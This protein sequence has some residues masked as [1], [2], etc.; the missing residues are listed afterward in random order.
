MTHLSLLLDSNG[1]LKNYLTW[2][3]KIAKIFANEEKIILTEAHW[4]IINFLRDYH[5]INQN[6]PAIRILVKSLK[7]KY[8]RAM[9]NSLYLQTLFP[10]SPAVQ[11]ARISGLSKP[12][13]CI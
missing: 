12:K 10:I 13:R 9:G 3:P 11:A 7:E 4:I 1:F 8:G 6:S 5:T 2:T